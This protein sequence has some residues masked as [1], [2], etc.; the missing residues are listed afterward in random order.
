MTISRAFLRDG[1]LLMLAYGLA[2]ILVIKVFGT[3]DVM[4]FPWL[5]LGPAVFLTMRHG[6]G[7]ITLAVI[8]VVLGRWLQDA[9]AS[10]FVDGGR[11]GL[12][13]FMG[14]WIY[15]RT[16]GA[17]LTFSNVADYLRLYGVGL[18]MGLSVAA[19]STL[20]V[21]VGFLEAASQDA[22]HRTAG[23]AFGFI[24]TMLP[25]LA[26][27]EWPNIERTKQGLWE[28]P[29]IIGLSLLFGQVIFLD[30]LHGT[31]GQ[32]ARGYWMF[33]FVTL[34]AL[35]LGPIGTTIT[36]TVAAAQAFIGAIYG[37]GFFSDDI[38]RTHLSNYYFY[39]ISLSSDGAL[40]A[41][42]FMKGQQDRKALETRSTELEA[43]NADLKRTNTDLEQFAYVASHDLREPLRMVSSYMSLLDRRYGSS[44]NAEAHEFLDFAE[45]GAKRMD[46]LVQDLLSFSRIGRVADPLQPN[47]IADLVAQAVHVLHT[48]I[49]EAEA[50]VRI[51]SDLPVIV[52]S[53][54]E[55]TRVFQNLIGNA[56]K[57]RA[58]GRKPVVE[59]TCQR[60]G[61]FWQ[62]SV[63]DNGIGIG[64]D[65]FDRIFLI[66]QRLHTREKFDGT[67]IGLS[68][69]KKVAEQHG[70]RIWL[71]STVGEGSSF[72]FT[73]PIQC[74]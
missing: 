19:I 64:S 71:R 25:L 69:C 30:W 17:A 35:R 11:Y 32:V 12:V 72:F 58:E 40:V 9:S 47:S 53:K 3:N 38:S 4:R 28:G 13:L 50:D 29:L 48:S 33:L 68:V 49:E 34:A 31:V 5:L 66:F 70:G 57:F 16:G 23:A 24:I 45:D 63:S 43:L 51:C 39:I 73:L 36:I 15:R 18:L 42:L 52:C 21:Q 27:R 60:Q 20:Q 26:A 8:G 67:G 56:I 65:Y 55:I 10:M 14:A 6:Y 61:E 7:V 54:D 22:V 74:A 46:A 37:L 1:A 41:V 62:F 44:L 59:I 2:S